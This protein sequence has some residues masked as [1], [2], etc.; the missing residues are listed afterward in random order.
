MKN[1]YYSQQL[2]GCNK[3][4]GGPIAEFVEHAISIR[5][6]HL[7]VDVVTGIPEFSNLLCQQ[8][9]SIDRV[10][11]DNTLVDLKF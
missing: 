7:G 10:A 9:Y 1:N 8:L 11:E 6:L 4:P 3:V 5:L 2:T